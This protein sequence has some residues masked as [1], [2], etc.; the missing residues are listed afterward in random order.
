MLEKNLKNLLPKSPPIQIVKA[1][2]FFIEFFF[3]NLGLDYKVILFS[4]NVFFNFSLV[5]SKK[6]KFQV[7]YK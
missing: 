5:I 2:K 3:H 7:F 4:Y 1:P 6:A